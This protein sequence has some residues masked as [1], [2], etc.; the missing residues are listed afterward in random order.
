MHPLRG[1][2]SVFRRNRLTVSQACRCI[3]PCASAC[4]GAVA[5]QP[6]LHGARTGL[7]ASR[8]ASWLARAGV[9]SSRIVHTKMGG[10]RTSPETA[11][12]IALYKMT[13][14]QSK[15]ANASKWQGV[16]TVGWRG[17][18][19]ARSAGSSAKFRR[20]QNAFTSI[21]G[22]D[23]RSYIKKRPSAKKPFGS[24]DASR[25][26]SP[27]RSVAQDTWV[28]PLDVCSQAPF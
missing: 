8:L 12:R 21:H 1:A 26:T 15:R 13:G 7:Q 4:I 6:L 11:S 18:D 19:K 5:S 10:R 3:L 20:N 2:V 23:V 27:R 28:R 9:R 22:C 16:K 24:S 14:S 25:S 17:C